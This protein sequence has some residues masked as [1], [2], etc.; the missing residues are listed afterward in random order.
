MGASLKNYPCRL[1]RTKSCGS[2]GPRANKLLAGLKQILPHKKALLRAMPIKG[3][4]CLGGNVL[5]LLRP[6]RFQPQGGQI[7]CGLRTNPPPQKDAFEGSAHQRYCA[8]R[9]NKSVRSEQISKTI[10]QSGQYLWW[11]LP[12]K[13]P[14]YG[15]GFVLSPQAICPLWGWN[16][17]GQ[18]KSKKLPPK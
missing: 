9:G 15:G 13:V 16:L 14:F 8:L 12:S 11:V 2:F 1:K 3:I 17:C 7:T 6:H 5:D 10:T 18:S 4:V